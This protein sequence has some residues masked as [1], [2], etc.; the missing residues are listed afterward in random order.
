LRQNA[1]AHNEQSTRINRCGEMRRFRGFENQR[2]FADRVDEIFFISEVAQA[3][4]P[5]NLRKSLQL[6]V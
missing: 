5:A 2:H 3:P 4:E 6:D 1:R